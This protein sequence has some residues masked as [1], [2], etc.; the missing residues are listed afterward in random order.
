MLLFCPKLCP[1]VCTHTSNRLIIFT[2]KNKESVS[3]MLTV[4]LFQYEGFNN[5]DTSCP[6]TSVIII[7][8]QQEGKMLGFFCKRNMFSID[9]F[10]HWDFKVRHYVC[11]YV[12]G[13]NF[14]FLKWLHKSSRAILL[15]TLNK[16]TFQEKNNCDWK[17]FFVA[18][19]NYSTW[20]R[21]RVKNS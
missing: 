2:T 9:F 18:L 7:P 20:L 1:K 14:L 8:C 5:Y 17:Y 6:C 15:L 21:N 3:M 13:K 11:V 10:I 19:W 12:Y 16:E 4:L